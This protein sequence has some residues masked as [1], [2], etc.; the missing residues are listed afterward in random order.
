MSNRVLTLPCGLER[1][2]GQAIRHVELQ[3]LK[4]N[5]Q[6]DIAKLTQQPNVAPADVIDAILRPAIVRVGD[7]PISSALLEK[8]QLADKDWLLFQT[9]ILQHGSKVT[10]SG[11]CSHCPKADNESEYPDFDLEQL[12]V[13]PIP[14]LAK[15][16]D[17]QALAGSIPAEDPSRLVYRGFEIR[18]EELGT[19]GVF[20]Y[21]TGYNQR[22][23]SKLGPNHEVESIWTLMSQ[24]CLS[25]TSRDFPQGVKIP[26]RGLPMEFW[27][28]LDLSDLEWAQEAWAEAQ[29][30]VD[31]NVEFECK[32]GHK[33]KTLVNAISFFS[34]RARQKT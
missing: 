6:L 33:F 9:K 15:W 5:I 12:K 14:E 13:T 8:L 31:T 25:W 7:E 27:G 23:I 2:G 3:R 19:V 29:P 26:P 1:P 28:D 10:V 24:T 11:V 22:A 21:P 17:G 34:Q 20:R 16:W 32:R 18:N 4:G 30:G